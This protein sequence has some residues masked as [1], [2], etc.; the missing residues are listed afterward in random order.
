MRADDGVELV[1]AA[2]RMPADPRFEPA[3]E[4]ERPIDELGR[5]RA[6]TSVELDGTV[7]L[8]V[9]RGG[10]EGLVGHHT[11]NH[12]GGDAACARYE[13]GG[14]RLARDGAP[15]EVDSAG[16][17][18]DRHPPRPRD[19]TRSRACR[20]HSGRK[21]MRGGAGKLAFL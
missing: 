4:P 11:R 7:Q 12:G 13:H 17:A 14:T 21:R 2:L 20:R 10:G 9:Q 5:E 8:S 16:R 6:V 18:R 3:E 15:L 1:D 19:Q